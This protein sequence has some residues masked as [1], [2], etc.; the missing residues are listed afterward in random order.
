MIQSI[1]H[2][3]GKQLVPHSPATSATPISFRGYTA[4]SL[5]AAFREAGPVFETEF[6]D[7]SFV[8]LAGLE[9]NEQAWR[10]PD[11]WSYHEAVAVFR[12]ELSELHLTQLDRE[13]H[14]RKRRLLNKGFKNSAIMS[15]MGATAAAIESGLERL[16]GKEVEL[17]HELMKIFTWAQA[18][19]SVKEDFTDTEI[20]QMVDFEEGFIGALFMKQH[21]R[22]FVYNRASYLEVKTEVLTRLHDIVKERLTREEPQDLLDEII[23]QKTS[24][25]L[26]PLSEE[27]LIYDCY[28]ML[29]AGTGNTS[30]LTAYLLD[31]LAR[32]PDWTKKLR[33]EIGDFNPSKFAEGMKHFPLLKATIMETER[34]FPAAPVLPRVPSEDIDFL[35]YPIAAGTRCLHLASLMHFDDTVYEEP[36]AFKPQRWLDHEY[37]KSAHGTFGGGSH[38]CLGMNVSRLQIPLTIAY[39]VSG[40][41]FE[42]TKGPRMEHYAYPD[43]LDSSTLRMNVILKKKS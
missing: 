38:T 24:A 21:E 31:A 6:H 25:T 17:H 37:P 42:V 8:I 18:S 34:M 43:E 30:K 3:P 12:E 19:T 35:G 40:Y 27:E 15:G 7:E 20:E 13:P 16:V 28:L 4:E 9:A 1:E 29:I 41:D 11:S 14:R 33:E 39:L 36:F 26:E 32:Y 10:T 5:L 23:Q 22:A 2:I